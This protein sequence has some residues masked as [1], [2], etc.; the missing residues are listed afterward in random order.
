MSPK[1]QRADIPLDQ[2]PGAREPQRVPPPPPAQQA[3]TR[4]AWNHA[5]AHS[6]HS[7]TLTAIRTTNHT[8]PIGKASGPGPNVTSNASTR[9]RQM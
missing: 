1:R 6:T 2:R 7:F 3:I 9:Y 8:S 5:A 4:L